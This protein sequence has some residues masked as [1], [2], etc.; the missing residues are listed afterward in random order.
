MFEHFV[1]AQERFTPGVGRAAGRAETDALDVVHLPAASRPS[2]AAPRL[3]FGIA[4]LAEARAYLAH[5]VLGRGSASVRGSSTGLAE[6][7]RTRSL[8]RRTM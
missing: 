6:R 1:A 5:P 8:A 4:D 2:A 3:R 7:Q